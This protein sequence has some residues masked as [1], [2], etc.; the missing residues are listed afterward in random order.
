METARKQSDQGSFLITRRSTD[1]HEF[2]VT[3]IIKKVGEPGAR[4]GPRPHHGHAQFGDKNGRN[5][6][7]VLVAYASTELI[8]GKFDPTHL[9]FPWNLIPALKQKPP[10]DL[11]D[12]DAIRGWSGSLAGKF[13]PA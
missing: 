5:I 8:D 9:R 3:L 4:N 2:R 12:W 13:M 6:G 11:R 10:S 7:K 1:Q